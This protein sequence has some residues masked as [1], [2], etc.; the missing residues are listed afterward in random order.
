MSFQTRKARNTALALK[1]QTERF[2][3]EDPSANLMPISNL[4]LQ[5]SPVTAPNPEYTGSVDTNG[6]EVVGKICTVSYDVNLRAPGGADVPAAGAYL[7]GILLVNAK[8][9]E[10]RTV[11]AIPASP[12]SLTSGTETGFTGG[13][14][15]TGTA[16]LYKAMLVR[17]LGVSTGLPGISAIRTNTAGKAVTLC[18]TFADP[19][20][21]NYQIPKQLSYVN[22]VGGSDPLPIS[23]SVWVGGKRYDLLDCQ[24]TALSLN[25][26]TSTTRTASTPLFRVTLSAV[27]YDTDDEATPAIPVLGTTPK[28]KNGKQFVANLALGGSG[29]DLNFG[30]TTDAAPNPNFESGDEGDEITGKQITLTPNLLAY[31]KADFD[32]LALAD[33]QEQ[34]SY[35]ALWGNGSGKTVGV[36][37]PDGRF[38]HAGDD[39]GGT[40]VTQSPP[41]YVDVFQKNVSICFPYY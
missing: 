26:Q 24:V 9:T 16:D 29:F 34:H 7:P 35:F 15:M 22:S 4:N 23:Q 31:R 8:M 21:G 37:I 5:I 28:F 3:F 20:S 25:V 30:I 6:D 41:L 19:L 36:V 39:V 17:L 33:A 40:F 12:E 38:G 10:V 2:V 14:G 18:E 27:I 1:T 11:T 13:V 32:Q